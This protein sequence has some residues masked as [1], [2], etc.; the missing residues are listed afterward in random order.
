MKMAES[1]CALLRAS[2]LHSLRNF[3]ITQIP[4]ASVTGRGQR[5][6]ERMRLVLN[7]DKQTVTSRPFTK[8]VCLKIHKRA[9]IL[10]R[11]ASGAWDEVTEGWSQQIAG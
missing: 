2:C 1:Y 3:S 10:A 8:V 9:R 4:S 5:V 6:F 11:K 7:V